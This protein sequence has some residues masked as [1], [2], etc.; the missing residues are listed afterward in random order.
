MYSVILQIV[1]STFVLFSLSLSL[2]LCLLRVFRLSLLCSFI[3]LPLFFLTLVYPSLSLWARPS[4][5][6]GI[7][8]FTALY[9][10]SV[11]APLYRSIL[12][13]IFFLSTQPSTL[14]PS[15]YPPLH[16]SFL[17]FIN[18]HSIYL[19]THPSI[20]PPK[21]SPYPSSP[22]HPFI[23]LSLH[24]FTSAPPTTTVSQSFVTAQNPWVKASY[25]TN[26]R[27]QKVSTPVESVV[28]I[29]P[30]RRLKGGRGREMR[31]GGI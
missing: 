15:F 25:V 21:A 12:S 24:P 5:Q 26:P 19:S 17:S 7:D 31:E 13:F 30:L 28:Y 10:V 3:S 23:P 27:Q 29:R 20:H 16:S 14:L 18:H 11:L 2:S 22:F 8:L 9:K 4:Q 6:P 1:N